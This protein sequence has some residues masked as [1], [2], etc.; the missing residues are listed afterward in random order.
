MGNRVEV[1]RNEK[2]FIEKEAEW[3]AF[4]KY[5]DHR[6][7]TITYDYLFIF[8]QC[9]KEYDSHN[10]GYKRELLILFLYKND[11]LHAIAPFCKIKR[12]R[13]KLLGVDY[14]EFLGQQFLTNYCDII[15]K[16]IGKEDIEFLFDWLFDNEKFDLVNLTQIPEYSPL[17]KYFKKISFCYSACP[18]FSLDNYQDY[19]EYFQRNYSAN[20]RQNLRKALNRIYKK[21]MVYSELVKN[22][23]DDDFSEIIRLSRSKLEDDKYCIYDDPAKLNFSKKIYR[24]FA[25]QVCFIQL[26]DIKVAFKTN[27][28]FNGLKFCYDTSYDRDYEFCSPGNLAVDLSIRDSFQTGV[29]LHSEGWGMDIYKMRFIKSLTIIYNLLFKGNTMSSKFWLAESV[30]ESSLTQ[31]NF[32]ANL[33]QANL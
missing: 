12:K 22:L 16:E 2:D 24:K 8:W 32:K 3:K 28:Y 15:S 31:E 26:N 18:E 27:I 1:V 11:N 7:I 14:I 30:N 4:E 9:F 23:T 20:H 19:Q 25:A 5:L 17:I 6:S 10:L 21:G 33:S 13:K 29:K